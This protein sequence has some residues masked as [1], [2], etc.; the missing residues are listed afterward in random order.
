M[1]KSK[2]ANR[3]W[4]HYPESKG[5]GD[6]DIMRRRSVLE[7]KKHPSAYSR[8]RIRNMQIPRYVYALIDKRT[9]EAYKTK[10]R[11]MPF[12]YDTKW[13]N[14]AL[15]NIAAYRDISDFKVVQYELKEV[16]VVAE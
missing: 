6:H 14:V 5:N 2:D 3:K 7:G 8:G 13:V 9:G 12:Y 15:K 10:N 16:Q 1:E 4:K 11:E